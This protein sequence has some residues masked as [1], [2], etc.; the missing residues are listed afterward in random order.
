[1][2]DEDDLSGL[3]WTK[4]RF[5]LASAK[6][7]LPSSAKFLLLLQSA[8][9]GRLLSVLGVVLPKYLHDL[10]VELGHEDLH[11]LVRLG[12]DLPGQVAVEGVQGVEVPAVTA[13]SINRAMSLACRVA[14]SKL[15][16][17]GGPHCP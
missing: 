16:L 13:I 1:M 15:Q 7:K 10:R 2:N 11:R 4:T 9:L 14:E 8:N 3:D 17:L 12:V 5:G 6:M